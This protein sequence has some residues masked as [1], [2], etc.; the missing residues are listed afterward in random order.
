MTNDDISGLVRKSA[1]DL[2]KATRALGDKASWQPMDKGRS[3]AN[4]VAEC[5][6]ITTMATDALTTKAVGPVDWEA[7]GVAQAALAANPHEAMETLAANTEALSDA[8]GALS[9]ADHA[10]TVTMPWDEVL[11]LP[12]VAMLVHWNNTYHEGQVNYIQTLAGE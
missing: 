6:L 12:H 7:F 4:Q 3:A 9:E 8:I 2:I 5:A 10:L 11:S 1:A